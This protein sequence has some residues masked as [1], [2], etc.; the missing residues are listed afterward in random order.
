MTETK[1]LD[2]N[3]G[4]VKIV[5][6]SDGKSE[7][8]WAEPVGPD[9]YRLQN[10]PWDIYG[11]NC[12][13]IIRAERAADG[14]LEFVE[15]VI[16]GGAS[17]FRVMR[18]EGVGKATFMAALEPLLAVGCS[19]EQSFVR[20]YAIHVPPDADVNQVT[21]ALENGASAGVWDWEAGTLDAHG[22][23][24]EGFSAEDRP[25][26][27]TI[28]H[29]LRDLKSTAIKLTFRLKQD[30][31]GYPP[32]LFESIHAAPLEDGTYEI[33][34]IPYFSYDAALGDV[35]KAAE[36]PNEDGL[37][38]TE[39]IRESGNSVIRVSVRDTQEY[40]RL[41]EKLHAMGCET[42]SLGS[43]LAVSIPAKLAYAPIF[44]VLL[45]GQEEARWGFEEAVLCHTVAP[46]EIESWPFLR[47]EK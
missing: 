24:R 38:F 29:R 39:L 15:V 19:Y 36:D 43:L 45:D 3:K 4:M 34:N 10:T 14:M 21:A 13:D 41:A 1:K 27:R 25:D 23:P 8:M 18:R 37:F 6:F 33:A 9:T 7:S 35:V 42:E 28:G 32:Y 20:L 40:A 22:K 31:D 12:D 16:P 46:G 2:P 5:F 26:D 44:E 17:T 30:E 11:V 47:T